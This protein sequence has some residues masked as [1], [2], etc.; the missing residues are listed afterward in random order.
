ME[1][2]ISLDYRYYLITYYY[3]HYSYNLTRIL[4]PLLRYQIT[5]GFK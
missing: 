1:I 3:I 2:I 4:L 5:I